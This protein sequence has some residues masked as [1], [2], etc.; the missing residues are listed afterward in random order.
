MLHLPETDLKKTRFYQEAYGE[1]K[2]IG[3]QL[4]EQRGEQ[5]GERK[6]EMAMVLRLL[7]RRLGGLTG[8]QQGQIERLSVDDLDALGEALLDFRGAADLNSWLLRH[9]GG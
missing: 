3:E 7:N 8:E 1:G 4:G 2:D 9:R 6:G 5:R